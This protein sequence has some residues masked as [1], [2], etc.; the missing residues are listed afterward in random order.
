MD[1]PL[2]AGVG[3]GRCGVCGTVG[4][5]VVTDAPTRETHRCRSCD[6]S[7]RYRAQ[8]AA[9]AW[10]Y[11]SPELALVE[12]TE[13]PSFRE[14][15]IYEP[16]IDGPLRHVLGQQPH[17]VNSYFWLDVASGD[18][19]DG[20][21]SEDLRA[22]TFRDES[23]DLVISSDI[24]EHVRGPLEAFAE[25]FRVLRPGGRHIFTVPLA[26]PLPPSTR[27]RVDYSGPDD[28]FALP[29]EYH[30]SPS[31]PRGSLV[32]TD[33]GMDLPESLRELGFETVT[34]HGYRKAI[35]FISRRPVS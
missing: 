32:Y 21:R 18:S 5:F 6:A 17:Y 33:F 4:E 10:A 25:I 35:T 3:A 34:H 19:L 7:L 11:A 20:V 12:L 26:W 16:G 14:L 13:V 27:S 2:S 30:G 15:E 9:I 29:P 24:L 22:L 28:V 23:F 8:A 1:G 31:D